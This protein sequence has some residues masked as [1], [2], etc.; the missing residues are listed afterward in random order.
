MDVQADLSDHTVLTFPQ[1]PFH[2]IHIVCF[3]LSH[4]NHLTATVVINVFVKNR[5]K[6]F[7]SYLKLEAPQKQIT[8]FK[9]AKFQSMFYSSIS[10][11]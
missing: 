7:I 4:K 10:S 1:I 8:K 11:K 9:S 2:L 3:F 6:K 5:Y